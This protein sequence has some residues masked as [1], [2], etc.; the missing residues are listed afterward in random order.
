MLLVVTLLAIGFP[1]LRIFSCVF[2]VTPERL[3]LE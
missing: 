1:I 3:K 2:E